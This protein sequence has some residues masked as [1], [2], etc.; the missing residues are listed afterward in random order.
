MPQWYEFG[1]VPYKSYYKFLRQVYRMEA[2]E[3]WRRA[4][5][6]RDAGNFEGV[7]RLGGFPL[8]VPALPEGS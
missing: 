4:K 5:P 2:S 8:P 7:A 1:A 3:E 6:L